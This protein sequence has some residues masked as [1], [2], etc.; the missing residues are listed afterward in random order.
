MFQAN[1]KNQ[2]QIAHQNH[3]LVP[4]VGS[5]LSA[6]FR[7]PT[8]NELLQDLFEEYSSYPLDKTKFDRALGVYRYLDAVDCLIDAGVD[9]LD[10]QRSVAKVLQKNL[11]RLSNEKPDNIYIDLSEAKCTK[12]ITTNY[13][14]ILSFYVGEPPRRIEMLGDDF[15]NEWDNGHYDHFVF[16]IHGDYTNPAS[17]VLS[18][19]SYLKLYSDEKY[20]SILELFKYKYTF[21]FLGFSMDD[22]F[23]Q[24]IFSKELSKFPTRHFIV[25]ANVDEEKRQSIEKKYNVRVISYDAK[26]NE[27]HIL[28]L[29][30]VLK[31]IQSSNR[32]NVADR[33]KFNQV[34]TLGGLKTLVSLE[35][36]AEFHSQSEDQVAVNPARNLS[37]EYNDYLIVL[38]DID[39]LVEK[40]S[41]SDALGQYFLLQSDLFATEIPN[42]INLRFY[43]GILTCRIALRKY[44]EVQK[45]LP[46]ISTFKSGSYETQ[47]YPLLLDFFMNTGRYDEALKAIQ[48]CLTIEPSNVTYIGML[49]YVTAMQENKDWNDVKRHFIDEE[50]NL[51]I[52]PEGKPIT[53][54]AE[55]AY[56]YRILGEVVLV[57]KE[58]LSDARKAFELSLELE[59][60]T[61]VL[62][63]LGLVMYALAIDEADDGKIIRID[64]INHKQLKEAIAY[65]D[66]AMD[67][68]EDRKMVLSR[69]ASIYLRSLFY[70]GNYGRFDE[71]LELCS[72][73]VS[74][75][76]SE[77]SRM[78]AIVNT[79]L[80]KTNGEI[81][82]CISEEDKRII[83][84]QELFKE[85][86]YRGV[87][88]YGDS[89]TEE[90]LEADLYALLDAAFFS[91]DI[92]TYDSYYN[93]FIERYPDAENR[94]TIEAFKHEI[95]GE[96]EQAE[97]CFI[98]S[99]KTESPKTINVLLG[100]YKRRNNHKAVSEIYDDLLGNET[101]SEKMNFDGIYYSYHNYLMS[102][103]QREEAVW[104]YI[105]CGKDKL[106]MDIKHAILID[107]KIYLHD[108]NNLI[109]YCL[110]MDAAFHKYGEKIYN[111]YAAIGYLMEADIVN[112]RR[113]FEK[114]KRD[115]YTD[116]RSIQLIK[117]LEARLLS[118]EGEGY[119]DKPGGMHVI[120]EFA[121][122]VMEPNNMIHI[123]PVNHQSCIMDSSSLYLYISRGMKYE[124]DFIQKIIVAHSSVELLEFSYMETGDKISLEVLD[125]IKESSNVVISS[126]DIKQY[127]EIRKCFKFNPNDVATLSTTAS[128][129]LALDNRCSYISVFRMFLGVPSTIHIYE[130]GFLE[131]NMKA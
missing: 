31:E 46:Q 97:Q 6:P 14:N 109:S 19:Q 51:I 49:H 125:Y 43:K 66:C 56:L 129:A 108:G 1:Y 98:E 16:N 48:E 3:M 90:F 34:S 11:D 9:E 61:A 55:R 86:N 126:P 104:L 15:V 107:L 81:L 102:I 131:K 79:A 85:G 67:K 87:L 71:M 33:M 83:A 94:L 130:Y 24:E 82:S 115:G 122:K 113:Y 65:F 111:Y 39:K 47:L 17:I 22:E 41:Y 75:D 120:K 93:V 117:E 8:W 7:I 27:D 37:S 21:I 116:D 101:L 28:G 50:W 38:D 57:R 2:L 12:Y 77:I 114:Y 80:G 119:P 69:I 76:L 10:L 32:L 25:L 35:S 13:D 44:N 58:N 121:V 112:A 123:H 63:D 99:A 23:I 91:G 103:N 29:R 59:E 36:E 54:A 62:E 95:H 18:R 73:F 118:L 100:F 42:D 128:I 78:N 84:F 110:E 70:I 74:D 26:T 124:L 20:K 64:E 127:A 88:D 53:K 105:N 4:F 40:G 68:A 5:G 72:L 52:A 60:S 92:Q 89:S 106:S 96:L 45:M 30:H